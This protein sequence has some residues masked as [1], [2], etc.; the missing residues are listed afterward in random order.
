MSAPSRQS[1][2]RRTRSRRRQCSACSRATS[3]VRGHCNWAIAACRNAAGVSSTRASALPR[4]LRVVPPRVRQASAR[5]CESNSSAP[6]YV[7][8]TS[9]PETPRR[10]CSDITMWLQH[11][12]I[13]LPPPKQPARPPKSAMTLT[14]AVR[15]S[16]TARTASATAVSPALASCS[17]TPPVS[18]SSR[19][20]WMRPAAASACAARSKPT[21]LAPCTSP[22]EPPMKRPSCAATSTGLPSRCPRPTTMPSSKAVGRSNCTRWGLVTPSSGPMNSSKP[23][24]SSSAVMRLRAESSN[25]LKRRTLV[26]TLLTRSRPSAVHPGQAVAQPRLAA[27]RRR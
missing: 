18:S 21:S 5:S 23:P 10:A 1:P 19:Q 15:A 11:A 13:R 12:A 27:R 2:K 22:I 26:G 20:A 25:Q 17:R 14:P 3:G 7:S 8:M 4:S 24:A 16:R 6:L 9:G